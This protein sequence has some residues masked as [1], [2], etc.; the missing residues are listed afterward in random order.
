MVNDRWLVVI[1]STGFENFS[2]V[3]KIRIDNRPFSQRSEGTH[4][5][6][7]MCVYSFAPISTMRGLTVLET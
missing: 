6:E 7:S 3:C 4:D 5:Q 2:N 1:F